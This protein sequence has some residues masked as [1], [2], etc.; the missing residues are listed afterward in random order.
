MKTLSVL[1]AE[2]GWKQCFLRQI[3]KLFK[4]TED[5]IQLWGN[6]RWANS[7]R[8]TLIDIR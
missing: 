1:F 3:P 8:T 5:R 2:I 6:F 4:S 7:R